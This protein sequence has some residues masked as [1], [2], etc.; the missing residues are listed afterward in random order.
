MFAT[1]SCD[2]VRHEQVWQSFTV[3]TCKVKR[4]KNVDAA[5][6]VG[7]A[8]NVVYCLKHARAK[9]IIAAAHLSVESLQL[10]TSILT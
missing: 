4:R 3:A 9:F 8:G 1:A 7:L 10:R 6:P 2:Y 5:V